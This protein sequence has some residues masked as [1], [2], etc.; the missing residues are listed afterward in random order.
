MTL[1]EL[2]DNHHLPHLLNHGRSDD[3]IKIY[4]RSIRY[5]EEATSGVAVEEI[6]E[7]HIVL[8]KNYLKSQPGKKPVARWLLTRCESTFV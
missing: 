1:T 2:F 8:F 4:R 5:W 7:K 3:T 6:T